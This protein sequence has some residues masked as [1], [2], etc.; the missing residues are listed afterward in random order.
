M[1]ASEASAAAVPPAFER[2]VYLTRPL[3]PPLETYTDVLRGI[4][5]RHW[6][7]NGGPLHDALEHALCDRLRVAHL[8]LVSN[9]TTALILACR[10]LG[11]AG[12]VVTTPF[13]SPATVHALAWCGLTPVFADIDPIALTLDPAAVERAITARTSA[14]VG[15]HIY[16]MPCDVAAM[17]HIADRHGLRVIYDGAHTFGTEIA[18]E[19]VLRFGDAT[20]MSFH[21]TKLFNTAEGGAVVVHD[22]QFKQ[23][24]DTL[25]NLGIQDEVT[26]AASGINAKMSEFAAALGLTNL[27]LVEAECV[28]R[29]DLAEIYGARLSGMTG[30]S[31]FAI[32]SHIR[33]SRNYFV[34]RIDG[35]RSPISRDDLYEGLKR[36]NVFGRRYFYPLCSE[37]PPYRDLPSAD[38]RALRIAHRAAREVLCVPFYGDLG[39]VAAHRICDMIAYLW[40]SALR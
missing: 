28:A 35:E 3:L 2:P 7:T 36:F 39:G 10:A 14:I 9:W 21:A 32:P 16:G 1:P 30:L 26:V 23:R 6:L 20:I 29:A 4:W 18:N 34:L 33:D 37:F 19:P 25:R 17:Q 31:C 15:V 22:R 24:V 27:E 38:P 8:S 12:E 5:E 13:T 40:S 11:L